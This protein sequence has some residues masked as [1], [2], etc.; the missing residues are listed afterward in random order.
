MNKQILV[1]LGFALLLAGCA[2]AQARAAGMLESVDAAPLASPTAGA[3]GTPTATVGWQATAVS[4]QGTS[5]AAQVSLDSARRLMVDATQDHEKRVQEQILLTARADDWTATAMP[6]A[7]TA[8]EKWMKTM[9]PI[10]NTQQSMAITAVVVTQQAPTMI[11]AMSQAQNQAK[12]GELYS[13]S[14]LFV[15]FTSGLFI[16]GLARWL[17]RQADMPQAQKKPVEAVT[18]SGAKKDALNG[19]DKGL[20][21]T[22]NNGDAGYPSMRRLLLPCTKEQLSELAEGVIGR[23]KTLAINQWEGSKSETFTRDSF[24]ELRNF[25]QANKLAKSTGGGMLDLTAD[26]QVLLRRWREQGTL[27]H[28]FEFWPK[29]AAHAVGMTHAHENHGHEMGGGGG[30]TGN[31]KVSGLVGVPGNIDG[32]WK[33]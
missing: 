23:G 15:A 2:G 27:P 30:L 11:V 29:K 32:G 25:L 8:T 9:V 28:S 21:V 26:G 6:I 20:V 16:L 12:Y 10:M 4:A 33:S 31:H 1:L 18:S 22:I 19:L 14:Y 5:Q 13:I 24:V 7:G 3:V 17:F